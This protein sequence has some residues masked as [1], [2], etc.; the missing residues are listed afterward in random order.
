M[1]GY[2]DTRI[3][4]FPLGSNNLPDDYLNNKK[5]FITIGKKE[6]NIRIK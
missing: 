5:L 1:I 6:A 4:H 3:S 2:L